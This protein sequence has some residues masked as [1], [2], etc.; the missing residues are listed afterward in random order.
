M[1]KKKEIKRLAKEEGKKISK[2]AIKY[3]E[4]YLLD[5]TKKIIKK[6]ARNATFN[7]RKIIKKDDIKVEETIR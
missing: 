4:M 6:A 5:L 2:E 7:G 3:I 1:I